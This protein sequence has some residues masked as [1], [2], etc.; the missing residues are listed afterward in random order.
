MIFMLLAVAG[1]A[2]RYV[3]QGSLEALNST[4]NEKEFV[5]YWEKTEMWFYD[6]K[7]ERIT[8]LTECS[9]NAV[10][11]EDTENDGILF[12]KRPNDEGI[13]REVADGEAC[14]RVLGVENTKG[15]DV[16]ELSVEI[17]CGPVVDNFVIG[18]INYLKARAEPYVINI[19]KGPPPAPKRPLCRG[20]E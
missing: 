13:T 2:E 6:K 1:C 7:P 14:G 4:G 12:L 17:Y 15:L 20:R 8:L 10:I 5:V 19:I 3:Y 18:D 11:Y 16:G 9:A